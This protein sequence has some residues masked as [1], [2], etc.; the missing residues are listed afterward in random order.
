MI[1]SVVYLFTTPQKIKTITNYVWS[2]VVGKNLT[3]YAH[4]QIPVWL[5]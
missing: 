5:S 2:E 3:T 4:A 1:L